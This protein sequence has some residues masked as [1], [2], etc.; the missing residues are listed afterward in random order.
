MPLTAI[1]DDGDSFLLNKFQIRIC[2]VVDV[3][4]V[5]S[6]SYFVSYRAGS[7]PAC[8][9]FVS[10][11]GGGKPVLYLLCEL[12][13]RGQAPPVPYTDGP[14]VLRVGYGRGLP[15]PWNHCFNAHLL[16]KH[17]PYPLSPVQRV[18]AT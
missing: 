1:T 17:E 15:P 12:P 9:L 16:Q 4:H 11:Q 2:V 10:Y 5:V 13:G 3:C 6:P 18:M 14:V 7:S 8:T